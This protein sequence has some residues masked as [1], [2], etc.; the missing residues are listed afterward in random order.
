M[1]EFDKEVRLL[2]GYRHIEEDCKHCPEIIEVL[3]SV[4]ACGKI[5]GLEEAARDVE[6]WVKCACERT[7]CE[8]CDFISGLRAKIQSLKDKP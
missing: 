7:P 1:D 4:H 2:C 6:G 8:A 5:E 3:H